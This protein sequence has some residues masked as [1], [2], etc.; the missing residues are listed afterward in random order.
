M[1][2]GVGKGLGIENQGRIRRSSSYFRCL[3]CDTFA[4]RQ[5]QFPSVLRA[6][7]NVLLAPTAACY[8]IAMTLAIGRAG[9]SYGK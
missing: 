5:K 1:V 2:H 7:M 3:H 9:C 8:A 6:Y 4:S